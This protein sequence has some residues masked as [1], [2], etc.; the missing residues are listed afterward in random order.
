MTATT[1][2]LNGREVALSEADL[3]MNLLEYLREVRDLTGAKN[4]CG[5]GVCGACTVLVDGK[6]VR[7]CRER[8]AAIAGR[9]VVTIEGLSAPGAPLHPMQRAFIDRGAIQ[10]GFCTPGMVLAGV[11][12]LNRAPRPTRAE[13]RKALAVNL[14]RCTGYQ[15]IVDA[16]EAASKHL[17]FGEK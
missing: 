7:A 5:I 15:Q 16:I 12:L 1:T 4:G 11:A 9:E 17:P 3:A 13:I 14:C 10:C 6:A 2:R 8:V